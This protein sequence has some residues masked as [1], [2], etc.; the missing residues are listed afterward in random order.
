MSRPLVV[1]AL[2]IIAAIFVVLFASA[3]QSHQ[4]VRLLQRELDQA[5][6]QV[7]Q[8]KAAAG[9]LEQSVGK[10]KTEVMKQVRHVETFKKTWMR[11]PPTTSS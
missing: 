5:R 11:L 8:S 3:I 2:V 6:Q 1:S 10:L 4:H 9:D 7:A